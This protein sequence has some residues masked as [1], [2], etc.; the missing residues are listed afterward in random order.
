MFCQIVEEWDG[1]SQYRTLVWFEDGKLQEVQYDPGFSGDQYAY[2][3]AGNMT[4]LRNYYDGIL[5]Y[6]VYFEYDG[7]VLQRAYS[8]N[9]EG[10]KL[11]EFKIVDGRIVG[12]DH[13]DADG[14][15]YCSYEYRYDANGNLEQKYFIMDGES[16]LCDTHSYR[17]VEVDAARANYLIA[18]QQYLLDIYHN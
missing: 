5:N 10:Q 3:A 17:A 16:S 13:Y 9:P 1:D 8:E 7:E 12:K 15:M 18:Q 6:A 11:S 4:E 14:T 2:D